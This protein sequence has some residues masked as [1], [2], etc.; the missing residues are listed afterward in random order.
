MIYLHIASLADSVDDF[1]ALM[2][3]IN[4]LMLRVSP[5]GVIQVLDLKNLGW[6]HWS[7]MRD[8]ARAVGHVSK[9]Y[10]SSVRRI[11]VVAHSRAMARAATSLLGYATRFV[12]SYTLGRVHMVVDEDDERIYDALTHDGV[13]AIRLWK[14]V[15]CNGTQDDE[16]EE[17]LRRSSTPE[18]SGPRRSRALTQPSG[19]TPF[20]IRRSSK[21]KNGK[22][23]NGDA[24]ANANAKR[25]ARAR[26]RSVQLTRSVLSAIRPGRRG[27]GDTRLVD[28]DE[29]RDVLADS[30]GLMR[31]VHSAGSTGG[32]IPVLI[33]L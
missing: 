11:L 2:V 21:E 13:A 8:F 29:G 28:A 25:Y 15:T 5:A 19:K 30:V 6:S 31:S 16:A 22:D 23:T 12:S 14:K 20:I 1:G 3:G 9:C 27:R 7:R 33:W 32:A 18:M 17:P 10:P 24:T 4:E 26:S